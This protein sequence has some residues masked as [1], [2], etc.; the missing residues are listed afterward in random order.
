[1]ADR[2]LPDVVFPDTVIA[3]HVN[4]GVVLAPYLLWAWRQR[5][6]RDQIEALARTTNGTYKVN[7]KTL[8]SVRVLLPNLTRQA[9]FGR[10]Q[11]AIMSQ[12]CRAEALLRSADCLFASLQARAFNG[13]L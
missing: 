7:Q 1:M 9:E 13:E 10:R 12:R 5:S 11:A 3:G 4:E 8:G 2:D 6:V